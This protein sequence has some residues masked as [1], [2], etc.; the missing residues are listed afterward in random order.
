MNENYNVIADY[1]NYLSFTVLTSIFPLS[2]AAI[3]K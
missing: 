1:I 2:L 3:L